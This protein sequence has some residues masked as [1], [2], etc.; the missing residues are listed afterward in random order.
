[1]A[2]Q[3]EWIDKPISYKTQ[4]KPIDTESRS[5]ILSRLNLFL[6]KKTCGAGQ[7]PP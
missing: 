5:P 7:C 1:M 2:G 6:E 3:D 4:V